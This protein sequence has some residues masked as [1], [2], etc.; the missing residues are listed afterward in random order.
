MK[1]PYRTRGHTRKVGEDELSGERGPEGARSGAFS[2]LA[3]LVLLLLY[4]FAFSHQKAL[5]LRLFRAHGLSK[6]RRLN[7]DRHQNASLVK[8]KNQSQKI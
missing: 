2:G 7:L 4:K 3:L 8:H 5:W 1:A 6:H